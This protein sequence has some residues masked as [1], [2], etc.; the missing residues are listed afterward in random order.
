VVEIVNFLGDGFHNLIMIY[1][2][3]MVSPHQLNLGHINVHD[4]KYDGISTSG[5]GRA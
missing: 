3:F 4:S 5:E 1:G 2:W